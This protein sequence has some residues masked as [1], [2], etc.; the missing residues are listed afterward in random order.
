MS[1]GWAGVA[2]ALL[3][4]AC[5]GGGPTTAATPRA[6][7]SPSP[8]A[9]AGLPS[10]APCPA[11][12]IVPPPTP[13]PAAEP[14]APASAIQATI[15]IQA[16]PAGLS[17]GFGSVWTANHRSNTVTRI[18][19]ATNKVAVTIPVES[20]G[21]NIGIGGM[22]IG[23]KYVWL[24]VFVGDASQLW[25]LDPATNKFDKQF[26]IDSLGGSVEVDGALWVEIDVQAGAAKRDSVEQ[27]DPDTGSVLKSID[28]GPARSGLKY[29]PDIGYGLGSI[30][31]SIANDLVARVDPVAGKVVATIQTPAVPS[32]YRIWAFVGGKAFLALYDF[33]LARIDGGS[34]CVDAVLYLGAHLPRQADPTAGPLGLEAAPAGLYVAFDR[35]ALALVD[36]VAMKVLKSERLDQQDYIVEVLYAD[37]SIW[38][39]TFGNNAVLR[40]RPL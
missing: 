2:L 25:R 39:S 11:P 21:Q 5:A 28:L 20:S 18:D 37:G 29:T 36:P 38:Y 7:V 19:P 34:N 26:P 40:V 13:V 12:A 17:S 22:T 32:G 30:W 31:V 8:S 15:P 10:P 1:K 4:A 3:A 16:G 27:I 9:A 33:D 35:G 23:Q 24:P 6:G 14:S